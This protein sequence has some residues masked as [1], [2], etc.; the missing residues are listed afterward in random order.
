ML[1]S[2]PEYYESPYP[3]EAKEL[4]V[5]ISH[6]NDGFQ[7]V[8]IYPPTYVEIPLRNANNEA[9]EIGSSESTGQPHSTSAW[10]QIFPWPIIV[11]YHYVA[12][13]TDGIEEGEGLPAPT[14]SEATKPTTLQAM[15][16]VTR[17][18]LNA[19]IVLSLTLVVCASFVFV[20][21]AFSHLL[22]ELWH[23]IV[24]IWK[25][26]RSGET[27]SICGSGQLAV[28]QAMAAR[29]RGY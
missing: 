20:S 14:T 6:V 15:W 1:N 25:N 26:S 22:A 9:G 24:G 19:L 12:A 21:W 4:E 10:L 11:L 23:L 27:G 5:P 16:R 18:L 8:Q 28:C 17:V 13:I 3:S 29:M 7:V 2:L